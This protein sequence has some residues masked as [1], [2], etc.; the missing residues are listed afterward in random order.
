MEKKI[1]VPKTKT[2]EGIIWTL[3]AISGVLVLSLFLS[4]GKWG[5]MISCIILASTT[6][7]Y[8]FSNMPTYHA[9][10]LLN[11]WSG[12]M[13]VVFPGI[14]LKLPWEKHHEVVD[15]KVDLR[16]VCEET[17]ASKD[18]LMYVK[19]VYTIRVDTTNSYNSTPEEKILTFCSFEKDAIKSKGRAIFSQLLSDY[20]GLYSGEDLIKQGKKTITEEVFR[21]DGSPHSKITEFEKEHGS[22]ISVTLE[23]SDFDPE[24][25]KFRSM[26]SGANSVNDAIKKL[27]APPPE[28]SGMSKEQALRIVKLLNTS[29]YTEQDFNL[30]VKAPD[31]KN[32]QNISMVGVPGINKGKGGQK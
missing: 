11:S 2:P 27:M 17:Y 22:N 25:Q 14:N 3:I 7:Y 18:S 5:I 12:V 6:K 19:Y 4:L 30:N 21:P 10:I 20:Y 9:V 13:R 24:T 29:G 26:V 15:L 31:L 28:G 32:L 1:I 8:T 23:D 16:E